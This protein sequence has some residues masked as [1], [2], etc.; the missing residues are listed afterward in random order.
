[1]HQDARTENFVELG[2]SERQL[3]GIN[4][5]RPISASG[6]GCPQPP[7][8]LDREVYSRPFDICGIPQSL[9]DPAVTTADFEHAVVC[10]RLE[11]LDDQVPVPLG[12]LFAIGVG[13]FTPTLPKLRS[14]LEIRLVH[15]VC[16]SE[17]YAQVSQAIACARRLESFRMLSSSPRNTPNSYFRRT[18]SAP[19]R[20][21]CSRSGSSLSN[22]PRAGESAPASWG[23]TSRPLTPSSTTSVV[24]PQATPTTA[25]EKAIASR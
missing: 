17:Y 21:S 20:P 1:M 15:G 22:R 9:R 18:I 13:R 3:A 8:H 25:F 12:L 4:E 16:N 5:Q 23:G 7:Y 14:P 10:T 11:K 19:R 6:I 24:P 2:V